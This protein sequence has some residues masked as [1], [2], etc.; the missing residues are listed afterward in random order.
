[1]FL[2]Q[3]VGA[4]SECQYFQHVMRV[5]MQ[6]RAT[7]TLSI[8]AKAVRL[9]P[10]GK[11]GRSTGRIVT[12]VS[13]DCEN[14]QAVTQNLN[15]LWSSPARIVIS[16][17]L[18]YQQLGPSAFVALGLLLALIPVQK[19]LVTKMR[20]L[21]KKSLGQTDERVKLTNEVMGA[22]SVVKSYAWEDSLYQRI[23][24]VRAEELKWIRSSAIYRGWNFFI[25]AAIPILATVLTFLVFTAT[26]HVL[27]PQKAFVALSLFGVLRMPLFLLPQIIAQV[28]SAS[29]ALNRIQDFLLAEEIEES[30]LS[31][32]AKPGETAIRLPPSDF[33]WEA[34]DEHGNHATP[35]LE[36][37][38]LVVPAGQ[39]LGII[40]GTGEGKSSLLAAILGEMTC[41]SAEA[42]NPVTIRGRVAY[43]PQQAWIFN[44]TVRDNIL[45]GRP[46]DPARYAEVVRVSCLARD[47]SLMGAGDQ[48]EIGDKGVNLSGGQKQRISIA[49]AV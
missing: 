49:R 15:V 25:I 12:L 7:L 5:G 41:L 6:L 47:F 18:L 22:M 27:T 38:R 24:D 17:A 23:T 36:K 34:E 16:V 45:F 1:M 33:T 20:T 44:A 40:G 35:L 13:S 2:G 39:L 10:A 11:R 46:Y 3:V 4:F 14:L 29:V 8:F 28:T 9:S 30:S 43:V 31:P 42:A 21:L 26:G 37:L 48:T 19:V 32:A